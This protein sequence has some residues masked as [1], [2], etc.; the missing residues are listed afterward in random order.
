MEAV[1][2]VV[3]GVGSTGAGPGHHFNFLSKGKV[4]PGVKSALVSPAFNT[5]WNLVA[6]QQQ[7]NVIMIVFPPCRGQNSPHKEALLHMNK[8]CAASTVTT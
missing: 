1:E 6:E 8:A 2:S 7:K 5:K 3:V 4:P